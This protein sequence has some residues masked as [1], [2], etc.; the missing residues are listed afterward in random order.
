LEVNMFENYLK[1]IFKK[2]IEFKDLII[3]K[4]MIEY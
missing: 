3:P 2:E 1:I 4:D